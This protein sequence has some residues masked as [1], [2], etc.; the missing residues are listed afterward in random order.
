M[1]TLLNFDNSPRF[2]LARVL[3]SSQL[4]PRTH[5]T[6]PG[7]FP[8]GAT[9]KHNHRPQAFFGNPFRQ[10]KWLAVIA[11]LSVF[12]AGA[13][14]RQTPRPASPPAL[15]HHHATYE[16]ICEASQP[17]LA[18]AHWVARYILFVFLSILL[19]LAVM[20]S[21]VL[22]KQLSPPT[23]RYFKTPRSGLFM[24]SDKYCLHYNATIF[25]FAQAFIRSR[26]CNN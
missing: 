12:P 22:S 15:L 7:S 19:T 25:S 26:S 17:I 11:P 6:M 4:R 20:Q 9:S 2:L 18:F 23:M 3:G 14:C 8:L 16:A 24:M 5:I 10:Q 21:I 13:A 1:I